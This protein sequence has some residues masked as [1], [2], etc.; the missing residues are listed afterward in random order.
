LGRLDGGP[1]WSA[2]GR[3]IALGDT[4]IP[5]SGGPACSPFGRAVALTWSPRGHLLAAV[6]TRGGLVLGGPGRPTRR[7]LPEGW[8]AAAPVFDRRGRRLAVLRGASFSGSIWV[9]D[10][11]T[12]RKDKI[13]SSPREEVGAPIAPIWSPDG[14]WLL[15]RT[16]RSASLA[17]DG[18]PVWA[19]RASGGHAR[20][21]E[22]QVLLAPDFVRPCGRRVVVSAGSDRY[23][24]AHKHVD[25]AAPPGWRPRHLSADRSR[26]WY[27]ASCSPAATVVAATVTKNREERRFDTAERS[28]WLLRTDRRGRRVLIGRAGDG[29]SDEYPLWSRDG[30]FLLYVEHAAKPSAG[31][32]L[33]LFDLRTGRSRG[34]IAQIGD[35]LGYYGY[36]DWSARASWYQP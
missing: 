29:I 21:I 16:Y 25:L 30:R 31:A 35:G 7:L 1:R 6:T 23:V 17:A 20:M 11:R 26:S 8:G 13:Y 2:D 4:L 24:T 19:V 10:L 12:G 27:S 15:F 18:V 32:R 5:V 36:H 33:R 9:I 3:W 22:R 14:R 34:P 28:I